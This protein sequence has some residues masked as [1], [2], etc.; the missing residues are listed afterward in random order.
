MVNNQ[1]IPIMDNII[2]GLAA[3]P[4]H[5][6]ILDSHGCY[7]VD[8]VIIA[9]PVLPETQ[10]NLTNPTCFR[11]SDGSIQFSISGGESPYVYYLNDLVSYDEFI[12][13]L[14]A[15]NYIARIMDNNNCLIFQEI[16][17]LIDNPN[18]NCI[19]IPN[20]FTPNFDGINDY[21]IIEN[22][23]RFPEAKIQIFNRW[24]QELWTA[25]GSDTPWDGKYQDRLVPTGPYLYIV[26]LFNGIDPFVGTVTVVF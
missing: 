11:F 21:W 3:G 14:P 25:S 9:P 17:S 22:I 4:Y 6:L 20:A 16:I 8:S 19:S 10:F 15:N 13:S 24:G 5:I 26:N 7:I 1:E 2:A 12:D 23:W 18:N